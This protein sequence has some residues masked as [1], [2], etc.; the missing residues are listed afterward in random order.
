MNKAMQT[1]IQGQHCGPLVFRNY[2]IDGIVYAD[3]NEWIEQGKDFC[4][5]PLSSVHSTGRVYDGDDP[6]EFRRECV[7]WLYKRERSKCP[8][9]A[10]LATGGDNG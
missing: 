7:R 9:V 1:V 2:A 6:A 4:N 8:P 3:F 10:V 5:L